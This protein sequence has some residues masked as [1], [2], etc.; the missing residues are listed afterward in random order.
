MVM[1][2]L[3][4]LRKKTLPLAFIIPL[5]FNSQKTVFS[6]DGFEADAFARGWLPGL[7]ATGFDGFAVAVHGE[8]HHRLRVIYVC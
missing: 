4:P 8:D 6:N 1:F 2:A 7:D 5:L 3:P